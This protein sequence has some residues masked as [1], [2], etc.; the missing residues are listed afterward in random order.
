MP[1]DPRHLVA[2]ATASLAVQTVAERRALGAFIENFPPLDAQVFVN[3]VGRHASDRP[4]RVALL[5]GPD[6]IKAPTNIRVTT[7]PTEANVWRNDAEAASGTASIFM[8]LGPAPK[9]NSLRTAV[10]VVKPRALRGELAATCIALLDTP[11]RRAFWHA[12]EEMGSEVSVPALV[13]F[14]AGVCD[15]AAHS[16]A[17]LMD[18]EWRL[19]WHLGLIP[20]Q[21]LLRTTGLR[22]AK[23][24]IRRNREFARRLR[25]LAPAERARLADLMEERGT[26]EADRQTAAAL[27]RFERS[28]AMTQLEQLTVEE[29]SRLLKPLPQKDQGQDAPARQRKDDDVRPKERL[30]GDLLALE[31]ALNEERG[32]KAAAARFRDAIDPDEDGDIQLEEVVVN[33]REIIPRLKVGTT[34]ATGL[35]GRLLSDHLWGGLVEAPDAADH[36]AALKLLTSGHLEL[37]PFKPLDERNLVWML[38][39]AVGQGLASPAALSAWD[40]YAAARAQLLPQAGALTDHPL[41][42]LAGSDR[43]RD[44]AERLVESYGRFLEGVRTTAE[45]LRQAGSAEPAKRLYGYALALDV[46]FVRARNEFIA[47]AAP[48][49]PFHVWRWLTMLGVLE[50]HHEELAEIGIDVLEPLV[51]DPVASA[52]DLVLSP[53]AV[54]DRLTQACA[55]VAIGSFGALPLFGEPTARRGAKFRA[56][57]LRRTATRFLRLMPHASFGLRVLLVDPPSVAGAVEDLID[58]PSTFDEETAVPLHVTVVRTRPASEATDEEDAELEMIARDVHDVGGTLTVLPHARGLAAVTQMMGEIQPHLAVVFD[59]GEAQEFRVGIAQPPALSPLM[60]PRAYRYDAFD[61]RLDVVIAGEAAPFAQYHDIFCDVLNLPRTDFLGRRSGASRFSRDLEGI[62]NGAVWLIVVD[63]GIEP[64]LRIGSAIRLDSQVDAG[65]DLLTYTA[66]Q[67]TVEELVADAI[68]VS[69]LVPTEETVA[70]T[71]RQILQFSGEALLTLAKPRP[72]VALADTRIA[73]GVLGVLAAAR[74]YGET[75]PD[76]LLISLDEPVSRRWLLGSNEDDRHGDLL[77]VRLTAEGVVVECLEVKAHDDP[78]SVVRVHGGRIEGK[79]SVQVDQTLATLGR[80]LRSGTART[81]LDQARA[82]ILRDQLYRAVASRPYDTD[83]RARFVGMLEDLFTTGPQ[84]LGG[85]VAM[86]TLR[87]GQQSS[88]PSAP[89]IVQSAAGHSIGVVELVESESALAGVARPGRGEPMSETFNGGGENTQLADRAAVQPEPNSS[90]GEWG[91]PLSRDRTNGGW[92]AHEAAV[93]EELSVRATGD[94]LGMREVTSDSGAPLAARTNGD[95]ASGAHADGAVPANVAVEVLVGTSATGERVIWSPQREGAPLNNF[96]LLVTG[97][98]GAGKTQFLRALIAEAVVQGI[99]VCV[100]DFKND[101]A[102]PSFS[103]SLGLRVFDV[104]RDGL[105]FN[106]LTLVAD[107]RGEAQPIRQIHELA[108]IL[109]RIFNLGDQQEHQLKRAMRG[110]YEQR[111]IAVDKWQSVATLPPAPGFSDVVAVLAGD[112]KSERLLNRVSPLFDLQLF[113]DAEQVATTFEEL[114]SSTVVLDM[115]SLPDDRIKAAL[116]EFLI[117][118]LHGHMLRGDQPRELRRLLVFDEAWRVSASERLQ[119]L[120]REGRAFGIGIAIGTQFPGDIPENLGGNLATQLLLHN[121]NAEHRKAV[122]R[123]LTGSA[124]GPTA[125]QIIRQMGALQ[126]HEGFFRNQH[127][128]P[129][130]LVRTLPHY[131]RHS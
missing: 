113:P 5:G 6:R 80:V 73:K 131:E 14:A 115:H 103:E 112:A 54:G 9:I 24:A 92:V 84:H 123:T 79:A 107:R 99:P 91:S 89:L 35:F 7:S 111:G 46:A 117:V 48:T 34:Q 95:T 78:T 70:R 20:T 109:R 118:R 61:D 127:Y 116:A 97:D 63:Q 60:V 29:V 98:P 49:H 74:W 18:C 37:T 36:V 22:G 3:E 57:S 26:P 17:A 8:I 52:P 43:L 53:F 45:A 47:I 27:L 59:P 105:P 58:L 13:R 56:R 104:D 94:T 40:D 121:S 23:G 10:D 42:A 39:R 125:L 65:R 75:Y 96:S 41:L 85:L 31:L 82:D 77:G 71:L 86:V 90:N 64:T 19:V 62:A 126:K 2:K 4:L 1:L 33:R 44:A 128:S 69:G 28:G 66:H 25:Q 108:S 120:A 30:D 51:T 12:L 114:L 100:F 119:E 68:R 16:R 38:R 76:S 129:F 88:W 93:T 110:A 55:F 101:Y 15:A 11:E 124:S 21:T 122:A 106:P 87:S 130:V 67:E 102:D 32:V 72:D 50:E 81:A 83:R